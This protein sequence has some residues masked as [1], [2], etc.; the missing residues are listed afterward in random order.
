[1]RRLVGVLLSGYLLL[2]VGNKVAEAAGARRCHCAD[3]C[4]C[5]RAGL[6]LFRWVFP[7]HTNRREQH[8][9]H[10]VADNA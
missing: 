4:W 1:M 10:S 3:E 8:D 6:S 7:W 5:R 2:A 9:M